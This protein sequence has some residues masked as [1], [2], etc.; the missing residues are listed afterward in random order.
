M[1][2]GDVL[3]YIIK[4]YNFNCKYTITI[5]HKNRY[6]FPTVS[7]PIGNQNIGHIK[8]YIYNTAVTTIYI[9]IILK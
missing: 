1:C 9:Y 2:K 3:T 4:I 5:A 7:N 8:Q 6:T